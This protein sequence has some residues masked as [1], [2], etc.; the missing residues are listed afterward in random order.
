MESTC[1]KC[2]WNHLID[3]A[4]LAIPKPFWCVRCAASYVAV[5]R[6]GQV[7]TFLSRENHDSQKREAA[8]QN[9]DAPVIQALPNDDEVLELPEPV[10]VSEPVVE[11]TLDL[12]DLL[13]MPPSHQDA[14]LSGTSLGS[15]SEQPQRVEA[16]FSPEQSAP[17]LPEASSAPKRSFALKEHPLVMSVSQLWL[18][19]SGLLF[20][21]F[22]VLISWSTRPNAQANNLTLKHAST[23][24]AINMTAQ[25]TASPAPDEAVEMTSESSYQNSARAAV[26][27]TPVI[28]TEPNMKLRPVVEAKA[29]RGLS[30]SQP[31]VPQD[32]SFTVQVGS[33]NQLT[34]ADE[35]VARLKAAG[36]DARVAQVEIPKRGTWYRVQTGRF[37]T[38][39][40]A[41]RYITQ[42]RSKGLAQDGFITEAQNE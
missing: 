9:Q 2:R 40:E 35:R 12:E 41:T 26:A 11:T 16:L 22:I 42:L 39:D 6:D 13:F 18:L 1:P 17:D 33:Y 21:S 38:R 5:L 25:L 28:N 34:Q 15:R 29:A 32:G 10:L 3:V 19:V 7:K 8:V 20:I 27:P 23:N 36:L 37:F 30:L 31:D 4:L 14:R 24:S